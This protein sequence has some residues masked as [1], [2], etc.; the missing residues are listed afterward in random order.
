[1]ACL[2]CFPSI[3][4]CLQAIT[5]HFQ[6]ITFSQ[7]IL[8][9]YKNAAQTRFFAQIS[10]GIFQNYSYLCGVEVKLWPSITSNQPEYYKPINKY[11]YEEIWNYT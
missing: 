4:S 11:A 9:K 7:N 2:F 8:R 3:T 10:D 6:S 1:M 5:F